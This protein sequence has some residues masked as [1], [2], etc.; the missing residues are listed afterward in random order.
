MHLWVRIV[1]ALTIIFAVLN[2]GL[3]F[4]LAV[5]MKSK[6]GLFQE[7]RNTLYADTLPSAPEQD[8]SASPISPAASQETAEAPNNALPAEA[9]ESN[10]LINWDLDEKFVETSILRLNVAILKSGM[11]AK[12]IDA[13][14]RSCKGHSDR[15][16]I[17]SSVNMLNEDCQAYLAEQ[18]EA[19]EKF[20]NRIS[21]FGDLKELCDKIDM[22]N[23]EQAA[24]VETT[25]NNLR[26]MD[27]YADLEASNQR[28]RGE[29]RHL[30][31]ARD[32]IRDNHEAAFLTVARRENR[33]EKIEKR[34]ARDP[35]TGILNRIGLETTLFDWWKE[36]RQKSRPIIAALFDI[37]KFGAER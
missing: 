22:S 2:I 15:D 18:K 35:C 28:L 4:A 5:Y 6:S 24:Q 25:M 21:E 36:G 31:L 1:L 9:L 23:L 3:G 37:D 30:C 12:E 13:K 26:Y 8:A 32:T 11:K 16:V 27:F 33:L 20:I 10:P 29:I 17:E 14:L 7:P 34:L 19:G